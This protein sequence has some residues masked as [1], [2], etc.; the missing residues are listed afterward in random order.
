MSRQDDERSALMAGTPS[1]SY[2]APKVVTAVPSSTSELDRK[3]AI[4]KH[5]DG[6]NIYTILVG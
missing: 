4:Q 2:H 3:A 5:L 1:H 6:A